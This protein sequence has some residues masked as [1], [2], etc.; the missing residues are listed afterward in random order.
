M[1]Q[2]D[3]REWEMESGVDKPRN[4]RGTLSLSGK[5][6]HKIFPSALKTD[7]D[8]GHF[9]SFF[10]WHELVECFNPLPVPRGLKKRECVFQIISFFYCPPPPFFDSGKGG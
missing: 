1:S 4:N 6:E 8:L 5:V 7:G 10:P 3:Q 2:D 9:F